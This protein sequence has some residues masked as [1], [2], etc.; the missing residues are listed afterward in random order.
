MLSAAELLKSF[1]IDVSEISDWRR[2]MK[3]SSS[4]VELFRVQAAIHSVVMDL[5]REINMPHSSSELHM[6]LQKVPEFNVLVDDY[7]AIDLHTVAWFL[8]KCERYGVDYSL[9][10]VDALWWADEHDSQFSM[11]SA[12]PYVNYSRVFRDFGKMVEIMRSE[13][14]SA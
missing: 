13:R 7:T 3:S 14:I 11:S 6:R 12:F 9:R 10:C 5:S 2:R 1:P 8:V 4:T